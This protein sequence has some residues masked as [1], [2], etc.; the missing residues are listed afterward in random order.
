[1]KTGEHML[2]DREVELSA[3]LLIADYGEEAAKRAKGRVTEMRS[4]MNHSA[5]L[6]WARIL[7]ATM[8]LQS[9]KMA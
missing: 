6:A 4:A 9:R 2:T 5:A 7:E 3:R 1:M 8:E